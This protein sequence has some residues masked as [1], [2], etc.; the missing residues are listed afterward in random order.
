MS[1]PLRRPW[2]AAKVLATVLGAALGLA[3]LSVI[4]LAA[5]TPP[6]E[7]GRDYASPPTP[8]HSGTVGVATFL[9]GIAGILVSLGLKLGLPRGST[10]Q[11]WANRAIVLATLLLVAAG[12]AVALD[13][14]RWSCWP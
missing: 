14:S 7:C 6:F 11:R 5:A 13:V 12:G 3:S 1:T 10:D 8:L 9:F 4:L 2:T